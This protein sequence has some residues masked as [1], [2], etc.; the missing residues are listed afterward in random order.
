MFPLIPQ[1]FKVIVI[2][3]QLLLLPDKKVCQALFCVA[4]GGGTNVKLTK[5]QFSYLAL[6]YAMLQ[7]FVP[8]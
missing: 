7:T 5:K 6:V 4:K 8:G 1:R 3:E 2:G